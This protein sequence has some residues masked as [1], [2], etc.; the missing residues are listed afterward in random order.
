M[1][2]TATG[3]FPIGFRLPGGNWTRPYSN[4]AAF[5]VENGFEFLDLSI[6]SVDELKPV[7]DA[8]CGIGS[9]DMIRWQ[10]LISP[11]AGK[12]KDAADA[13]AQF[14]RTVAAEGVDVFFVVLLPEDPN[15]ARSENFGFAV[16]SYSRLSEAVADTGA[17]IVIEGWPGPG[18]NYPALAC[19]PEGYRAFIREV[20]GDVI[21]V[22]FDP[23]HLIRMGIDARRFLEEF[24][25]HVYHVHGKDTELLRDNLYEFGNLQAA[26]F[27]KP[28][29]FGAY[30]WRYT[31]PGYGE[32]RWTELFEILES[33]GYAGRV[34]IELEDDRYNGTDQGEKDGLIASRDFLTSV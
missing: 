34:S 20:P 7:K 9:I 6:E 17:K 22:N 32:S 29:G 11:D 27:A 4:A 18:P 16:D 5:A 31:I 10:D 26:T 25:P 15:R 21:G 3:D 1:A 33:A 19:T 23:S 14:I 2:K 24:A 13:N 8:G 28:R 30:H 12:R